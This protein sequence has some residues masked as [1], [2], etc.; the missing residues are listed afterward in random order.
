[1]NFNFNYDEEE[2]DLKNLNPYGDFKVIKP[3]DTSREYWE[4]EDG[5]PD[6]ERI[7]PMEDW[8]KF[9]GYAKKQ[10]WKP[11][12]GRYGKAKGKKVF[13]E[14]PIG[15][16]FHFLRVSKDNQRLMEFSVNNTNIRTHFAYDE[17]TDG[18]LD[19]YLDPIN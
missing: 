7:L 6:Y 18:I 12:I 8:K 13:F 4:Y 3:I 11:M 1:M 5:E 2:L 17:F 9:K 14:I 15:T 10:G 16:T 19:E